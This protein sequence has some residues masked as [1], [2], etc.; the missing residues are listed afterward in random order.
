[1]DRPLRS[2]IDPSAEDASAGENERVGT[3]VAQDGVLKVAIERRAR[4]TLP[5]YRARPAS[6]SVV[7]PMGSGVN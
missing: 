2:S 6:I 3:V 7:L 1:L 5:I 4:Y